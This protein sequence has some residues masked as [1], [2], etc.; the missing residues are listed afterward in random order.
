MWP[1]ITEGCD[2]KP[3]TTYLSGEEGEGLSLRD[4]ENRQPNRAASVMG[5]KQT[6]DRTNTTENSVN[7][8]E[9][10]ESV[11]QKADLGTSHSVVE[12][13]PQTDQSMVL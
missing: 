6:Q 12:T 2:Y 7:C 11:Q 4:A 13:T 8:L 1:Q 10:E 5:Q 3:C 9:T